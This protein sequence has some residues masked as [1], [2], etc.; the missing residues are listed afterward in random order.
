MTATIPTE[1]QAGLAGGQVIP[2]LGP[3]VLDLDGGSA[4]PS[5]PETLVELI[6]A[7]VTVPH[8]IRRNLTAAGQYIENFKHR[9][10]LVG[11][12][13]EA[14]A[15]APAPNSLH[16]YLAGQPLPLIVDA[17]YDASM[18]AALAGR[19]DFGQVQGVSRAEHFGEWVHYF[20]ADGSP[21]AEADA[22]NWNLLLYKPLGGIAPAANFILSDSDY[23]EVLTEIDIQ[24][25]IPEPVKQIRSGRH[26][27]F[28]GCRFRTQ[29]ERTY[30]RQIMKRSSDLHWAVLPDEPTRNE[31]RF[32]AEQRIRRIDLP[33]E[34]FV[35]RLAGAAAARQAA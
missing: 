28:L 18:A 9:K 11:L 12:L 15:A 23:V 10:T 2:Y 25:P 7:K 24:T 27:L 31:E 33:L 13:K 21:A 19:S 26:F 20:H 14:F 3:G 30:A 5:A 6:T 1:I 16:R 29:L 4:V 22:A 35:R 32:L 8:K 17:W 34:D